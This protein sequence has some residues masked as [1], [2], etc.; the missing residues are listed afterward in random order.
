[1]KR[2]IVAMRDEVMEIFEHLHA[3]P[4]VSWQEVETTK[5]LEGKLKDL[6]FKT[7]TFTDCTGVIGE[8]GE[9][10]PTVGLRADMDALWQEVDG[11]FQANHSCGHDAHMTLALGTAI[12]LNKI[13]F[14]PNGR[15]KILF[16]PAEEKGTGAL[17]LI[18]KGVLDDVDYLYG[19]HLRPIQ[20]L[21]MGKAAPAIL[22]GAAQFIHGEIIGVE[23]H[24][25]RPYLGIN[26]IE[27]GASL[28]QEI[29]KIHL[30][31][32]EP[33]TVKMTRFH[34]GGESDNII[35]GRAV[36]SLDLRA[37]TN[38]TMDD[39]LAKVEHVVKQVAELYRAE[40]KLTVGPRMPAAVLNQEAK[41]IMR[42]A[43]IDTLGIENTAEPIVSVG[44]E[45]FHFY[46]LERPR[47]KATMLGLGCD[48]A[49]G[50]HHPKMSFNREALLVGIEILAKTIMYTFDKHTK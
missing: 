49:P 48:L 10:T 34:A 44:S 29:S 26:A 28:V 33:Y 50:L 25:A 42:K 21:P 19:V 20:E 37:Q 41:E 15:L 31:P 12:L 8:L 39:L 2:K 47:I 36:F 35:P 18:E 9:G 1:M 16:Q 40:I 43:I 17:K 46:T 45:D 13:G 14:K 27:V 30:N 5:Y 23:A 7:T 24:G 38:G 32:F 4:E 3:H 22:N 11:H 6:G